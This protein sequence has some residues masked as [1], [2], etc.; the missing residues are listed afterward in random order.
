MKID[1]SEQLQ[2]APNETLRR[3]PAVL[4]Q[5]PISRSAWWRGI[6]EGR[7][8][9]GIRLSERCTAW[10]QSDLDALIRRLER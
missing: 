5:I 10:R 7:F 6:Q 9:K 3:L 1:R 2:K 4:A 8:P